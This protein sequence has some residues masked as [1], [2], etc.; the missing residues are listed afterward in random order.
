MIRDVTEHKEREEDLA[1]TLRELRETQSR[2]ILSGRLSAMGALGAGIAHELNQPLTAIQ[3]FAQRVLRRPD[4]QVA[5]H[6]D[7]LAVISSEAKRMARIVDNIRAFARASDFAPQPVDA[8]G[9]IQD[10]LMLIRR[11]LLGHGIEVGVPEATGLP[12]VLADRAKLQQVF[13]NLLINARDAL[14][15][16]DG[17]GLRRVDVHARHDD[18]FV[19]YDVDD[20]GP[21]VPEDLV[22]RLFDPFVTTKPPGQGTGLGLSI[23]YGILADH[24]GDIGYSRSPLGGA[25][26]TLRV[27]SVPSP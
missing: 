16:V 2:L 13:L 14:A 10:A 3:G 15:G 22:P 21:G 11:Q 7:E 18:G 12:P 8:I 17:V 24:D 23:I 20:S 27:P 6:L 1:R 25:R 9:P 4:T 5:D 26:F 19:V